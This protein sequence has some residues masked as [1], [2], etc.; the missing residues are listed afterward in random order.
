MSN[1]RA[2]SSH[3]LN[4]KPVPYENPAEK[5][6]QANKMLQN[7]KEKEAQL[8][9]ELW[10]KYPFYFLLSF[11][12]DWSTYIPR[13][14][15]RPLTPKFSKRYTTWRPNSAKLNRKSASKNPQFRPKPGTL[16]RLCKKP[17]LTLF[18][19]FLM[20]KEGAVSTKS[21]RKSHFTRR[22]PRSLS[23]ILWSP[24]SGI[25]LICQV[26]PRSQTWFSPNKSLKATGIIHLSTT[27]TKIK[28]INQKKMEM[29]FV[30]GLNTQMSFRTPFWCFLLKGVFS[31]KMKA[32]EFQ[33]CLITNFS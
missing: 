10:E 30:E 29:F 19:V 2:K 18:R 6:K 22:K 12:P 20:K 16:S 31:S 17:G 32:S 9:K 26:P 4:R 11:L 8:R 5:A 1:T 14:Q 25:S 15:R 13:L 33:T 7:E 24:M 28:I 27:K 21:W 23:W 3:I